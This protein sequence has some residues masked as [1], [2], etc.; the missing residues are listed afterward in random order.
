[1][2]P[3]HTNDRLIWTPTTNNANQELGSEYDGSLPPVYG[4]FGHLPSKGNTD[5]SYSGTFGRNGF[6]TVSTEQHDG[7][8]SD[9]SSH[10][11]DKAMSFDANRCSTVYRQAIASNRWNN[12]S[13]LD[14][15]TVR[16]TCYT[17]TFF[18]RIA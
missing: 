7:T 13:N 10:A 8:G 15:K 1:M 6:N 17:V 2:A 18:R 12:L 9:D 3:Y 4:H 14:L 11:G 5:G 16:P